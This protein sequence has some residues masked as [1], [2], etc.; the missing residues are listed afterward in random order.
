MQLSPRSNGD[1]SHDK[2]LA[3]GYSIGVD[4]TMYGFTIH[5]PTIP[6]NANEREGTHS[7]VSWMS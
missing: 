4:H 7:E 3:D 2:K 5:V 6:V 1:A